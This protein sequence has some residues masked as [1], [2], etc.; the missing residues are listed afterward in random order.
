MALTKVRTAGIN[1]LSTHLI[2]QQFRLA[3]SQAGSNSAGTYLTK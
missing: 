2:A 3:S 1:N